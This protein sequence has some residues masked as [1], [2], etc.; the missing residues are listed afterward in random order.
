[1]FAIN[2]NKAATS[3]NMSAIVRQTA[4]QI[5]DNKTGYFKPGSWLQTLSACDLY[6]LIGA[7]EMMTDSETDPLSEQAVALAVLLSQGEGVEI[8]VDMLP[9]VAYLIQLLLM[10][11]L[12]RKGY[13]EMFYD[14]VSFDDGARDLEIA[15]PRFKVAEPGADVPPTE[16]E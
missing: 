8:V 9:R 11:S 16:G 7:M 14:N 4:R 1:M 3:P 2:L 10:E 13:I 6:M 12:A 5:L 15:K